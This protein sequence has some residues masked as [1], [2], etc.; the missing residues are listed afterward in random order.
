MKKHDIDISFP[1]PVK[2]T[3]L[4]KIRE[5]NIP[6]KYVNEQMTTAAD[7]SAPHLSFYHCV[8][9]QI[10]MVRNQLKQ[11]ARHLNIQTSQ[12][13]KAIHLLGSVCDQKVIKGHQENYFSHVRKQ[14]KEFQEID[15][16]IDKEI[17]PLVIHLSDNNDSDG[18]DEELNQKN[19]KG[20]L[21]SHTL[22]KNNYLTV[23]ELN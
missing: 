16:I 18:S 4:V 6:K 3:L 5:A 11:H 1:L 8:F 13:G 14:E 12:T 23:T 17:E 15:H 22:L 20:S 10:E 21:Q 9:N 7:Y 19:R 2:S